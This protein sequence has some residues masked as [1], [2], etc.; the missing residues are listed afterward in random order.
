MKT[1]VY[2][3]W[4][5]V[6]SHTKED[7]ERIL[8]RMANDDPFYAKWIRDLGCL[9]CGTRPVELHHRTGAGMALRAGDR[10]GM[11]LCRQCHRDFHAAQGHFHEWDREQRRSWQDAAIAQLNELYRDTF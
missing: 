6:A 9:M 11:P 3:T 1:P 7:H 2:I 8:C 5:E 10:G 4:D